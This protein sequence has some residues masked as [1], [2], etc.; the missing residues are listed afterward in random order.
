MF[1]TIPYWMYANIVNFYVIFTPFGTSSFPS[2]LVMTACKLC[3]LFAIRSWHL[4]VIAH[5]RS[6]ELARRVA[7]LGSNRLGNADD[8]IRWTADDQVVDH[9]IQL[10]H[11]GRDGRKRCR[12][13]FP[14][15]QRS[16]TFT[17][18]R[19]DRFRLFPHLLADFIL[20]FGNICR[21]DNK[22]NR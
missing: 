21:L 6:D 7:P 17:S 18:G 16:S 11:L 10:V 12:S 20:Q 2:D 5:S 4:S 13:R 8:Q 9:V 19:A 14:P 3:R 1:M 22:M 15:T